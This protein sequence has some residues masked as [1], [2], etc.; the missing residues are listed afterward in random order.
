MG[1][2]NL[3]LFKLSIYDSSATYGAQLQNLKYRNE[4]K[5]GGAC[6]LVVK[7]SAIQDGH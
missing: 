1:I 4:W 2:L 5:H 6:K 7:I 3:V